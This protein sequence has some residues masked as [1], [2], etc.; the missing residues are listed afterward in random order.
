MFVQRDLHAILIATANEPI[1]NT[2]LITPNIPPKKSLRIIPTYPDSV[3]I[4]TVNNAL[5]IN[6]IITPKSNLFFCL[7]CLFSN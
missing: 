2:Y 6:V 7:V 4:R 3:Y 5:N 1:G